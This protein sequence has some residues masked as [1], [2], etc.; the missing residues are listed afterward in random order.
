MLHNKK[1]FFRTSLK[2]YKTLQTLNYQG[3]YYNKN[4][5]PQFINP[6]HTIF[7]YLFYN[8]KQ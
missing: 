4:N 2:L 1:G 7:I 5:Q 8:K 3:F 6:F